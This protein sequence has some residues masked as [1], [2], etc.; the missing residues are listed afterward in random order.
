VCLPAKRAQQA[1]QLA[2]ARAEEAHEAAELARKHTT[3][4]G[5]HLSGKQHH[6]RGG[7]GGK[8]V[9]SAAGPALATYNDS[10]VDAGCAAEYNPCID[11]L[12]TAYLNRAD[13]QAA[14]HVLPGTVPGGSWVSCSSL[15]NYSYADLLS[16][17][18]PTWQYLLQNWP[19]GKWLVFSGSVDLIVPFTGT[20]L[21]LS[22]LGWPTT[23]AF[24][25]WY[26]PEN[27]IGGWAYTFTSPWDTQ[28]HYA[29]V[30]N[31]GHLVPE[32]QASRALQMFTTFLAGNSL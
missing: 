32:L 17:M 6:Q 13:V 2:A 7:K 12:T 30:R 15:V 31:A 29:T 24:H 26:T 25:P 9:I 14:I 23:T 28:L 10:N 3:R 27:Q 21:W 1:A 22:T 5:R 16:S 8:A 19:Q 18:I 11:D 4:G 20:R